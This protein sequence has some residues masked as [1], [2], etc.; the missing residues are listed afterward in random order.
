MTS[1][2]PASLPQAATAAL[3]SVDWSALEWV[4]VR[5]G[6]ERKTFGSDNVTLALH[7]LMP[8]HEPLPHS[9]P[10]EQ[11]MYILAGLMDVHVDGRIVRLGPGG[12]LLIPP[13]AEHY[14]VVV[15]DEP[16]L[17]LDVFTPARPEY[18]P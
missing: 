5:R 12:L 7:R 2:L 3:H 16:V 9:H 11:V 1:S 17:N 13:N 4:P 18:H 15:G 14:G 8:G 10:N 6:I